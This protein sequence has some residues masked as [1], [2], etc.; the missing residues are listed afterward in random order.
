MRGEVELLFEGSEIDA[1]FEELILRYEA[2]RGAKRRAMNTILAR[3]RGA[4]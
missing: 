4:K 3:V 2:Q 1:A